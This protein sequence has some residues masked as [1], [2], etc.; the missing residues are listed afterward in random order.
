ML[1]CFFVPSLLPDLLISGVC[2]HALPY[3]LNVIRFSVIMCCGLCPG[4]DVD[5]YLRTL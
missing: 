4:L 5:L 1:I 3:P 2:P